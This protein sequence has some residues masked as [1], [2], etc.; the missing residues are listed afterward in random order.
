MVAVP[1]LALRVAAAMT[2][3]TAFLMAQGASAI[4]AHTHNVN[5]LI[6]I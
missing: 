4:R 2:L 6:Q 1:I 5:L 3:N